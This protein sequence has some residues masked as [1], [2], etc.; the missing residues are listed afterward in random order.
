MSCWERWRPSEVEGD[1][2]A[3]RDP[4]GR[5]AGRLRQRCREQEQGFGG[6]GEATGR[7]QQRRG[8]GRGGR[9]GW[10]ESVLGKGA[11]SF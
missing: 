10:A 3:E 2:M 5:R 7:Q 6:R 11:G 4:G 8:R 1:E 9:V